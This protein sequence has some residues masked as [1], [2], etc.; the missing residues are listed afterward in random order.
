MKKKIISLCL[1]LSCLLALTGCMC[2]H[3]EWAEANCTTPKTC[4]ECGETEGESLG[5]SW[6]AATCTAPKTCENCGLTDGEAKGHQWEEATCTEAKTCPV[7]KE[8]EGE[9]LGHSWLDA[10]T[11]EPKTCE[12]CALTEGERIITDSRFTTTSASPLF[13]IWECAIP[14]DGEAVGM[15]GM[16][17]MLYTIRLEF[18]H[19]AKMTMSVAPTNM[20]DYKAAMMNYVEEAVYA[21]M[22]SYGYSRETAYK[23]F[24]DINDM[25]INEYVEAYM[26]SINIE[27]LFDALTVTYVYYVDEGQICYSISWK[28]E[29]EF[30][31]FYFE[32]GKLFIEA[33][34]MGYDFME[35]TK[36][37]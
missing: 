3:E 14:L 5:H 33:E 18:S 25:T 1:V 9:P 30:D 20:D 6:M 10:T 17:E 22:A 28:S 34:E 11:M 13:G 12:V 21:E 8:V 36:V 32:D 15:E 27:A 19:D 7:C 16:E 37:D 23:A 29:M 26:N 35:M 2:S 4:V 24:E 31:E